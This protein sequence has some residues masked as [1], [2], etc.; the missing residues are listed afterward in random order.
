MACIWAL[1]ALACAPTAPSEQQT[2]T[3]ALSVEQAA[4]SALASAVEAVPEPAPVAGPGSEAVE[5]KRVLGPQAAPCT[6]ASI[7][8]KKR[9]PSLDLECE[10]K[11]GLA[12]SWGRKS[13]TTSVMVTLLGRASIDVVSRRVGAKEFQEVLGFEG[14]FR[15]EFATVELAAAAI[16][17]L[18]CD[19]QVESAFMSVL[20]DGSGGP[21][22]DEEC[23]RKASGCCR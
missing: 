5:R 15:L 11:A 8:H 3:G 18:L 4:A 1:G 23:R 6:W 22:P 19:A 20:L 16:P 12:G 9:A 7:R 21:D 2:G 10:W 13:P 17:V 14:V